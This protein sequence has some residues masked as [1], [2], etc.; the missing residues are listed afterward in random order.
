M[1]WKS[2]LPPLN[3]ESRG[4]ASA[5]KYIRFVSRTLAPT[6]RYTVSLE[7]TRSD[8]SGLLLFTHV[9]TSVNAT[10]SASVAVTVAPSDGEYFSWKLSVPSMA[11]LA[12]TEIGRLPSFGKTLYDPKRSI[13]LSLV[14]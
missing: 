4:D 12:L 10:R 1:F 14:R 2:T 6:P 13:V 9:G 7:S 11:A 8:G 5:T 3:P